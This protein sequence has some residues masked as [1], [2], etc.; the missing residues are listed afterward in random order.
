MPA[1]Q[2]VGIDNTYKPEAKPGKPTSRP[3]RQRTAKDVESE[4]ERTRLPLA[5]AKQLLAGAERRLG[6]AK[7]RLSTLKARLAELKS[8]P[9][10][11]QRLPE[12]MN[13]EGHERQEPWGKSVIKGTVQVAEEDV[14]NL[15]KRVGALKESVERESKRLKPALKALQA[16]L[17][18]AKANEDKAEGKARFGNVV[19]NV[20]AHSLA[21]DERVRETG[22]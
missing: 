10:Y 11:T 5:S 9:Y 13:L 1:H 6:D 8:A 20:Q 2:F 4:M 22:F 7:S 12:V 14:A 21:Y 3:P 17:D 15:D 19:R 18:E 16:E